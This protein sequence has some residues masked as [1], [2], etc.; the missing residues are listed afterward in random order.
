MLSAFILCH[1]ADTICGVILLY[2]DL[3]EL[4]MQSDS[5]REY[6]MKLPVRV[7]M[8]AHRMNDEIRTPEELHRAIDHMTKIHG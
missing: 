3:H 2:Q 6:F 7:Q 8:T 5:T 1:P 4:L